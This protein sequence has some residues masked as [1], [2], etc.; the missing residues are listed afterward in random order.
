M[1]QVIYDVRFLDHLTGRG[2]PE[3]PARLAAFIDG[4]EA[5]GSARADFIAPEPLDRRA[6]ATVHDGRYVQLI[7]RYCESLSSVEMLGELPTGDTTV[8]HDSFEIALLAAGA[9]VSSVERAALDAPAL[10]V[11]RPPGHHAEPARGMGF[12]LLNNVALAAAHARA[13]RGP[14]LIVDFDYHHGNGTQAWVER[15]LA[16]PGPPI[17]FI[18][19]HA[20]P[21]YP[22]TGAFDESQVRDGGFV[23][24][25]P[26]SH[27][28]N[29]EDFV[30]AWSSLLPAALRRIRPA[31][32]VVSAGFDFL[33]GDPIA[34]LP[35]DRSAV[36]SLCGLI[37]QTGAEAG[38]GI[39]LVL[40]GGYSLENLTASGATLA[41]AF[42]ANAMKTHV[43]AAK[44]PRDE[45]LAA[46]TREALR[47]L[48]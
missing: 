5:G 32:I 6:L 14:V 24:D 29:T 7:E 33:A 36:D 46:M 40:E 20:Y 35:I 3:R 44:L 2:H 23:I 42:G 30:A 12:C 1:L 43:P 8:G 19:T 38:A 22:G 47:W 4:L 10:A 21:A 34:G 15:A 48:A 31:A 25:V 45:R 39:A 26:L 16:L 17:G 9:S 11:V 13:T 27:A 18:S 41:R 28:T 37:G